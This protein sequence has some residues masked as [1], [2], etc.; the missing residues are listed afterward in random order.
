MLS[1][2]LETASIFTSDTNF[3]R[4]KKFRNIL[5]SEGGDAKRSE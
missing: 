2:N 1:H 3:I 4:L 5:D